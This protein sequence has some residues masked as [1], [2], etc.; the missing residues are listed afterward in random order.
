[1]IKKALVFICF[2]SLM[3]CFTGGWSN[4]QSLTFPNPNERILSIN[5]Y[6]LPNCP[7]AREVLPRIETWFQVQDIRTWQMLPPTP[8]YPSPT[9]RIIYQ[10]YGVNYIGKNEILDLIS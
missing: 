7:Y 3:E 1:M 4:N 9:L 10:E 5:L 6:L 2:W 8:F